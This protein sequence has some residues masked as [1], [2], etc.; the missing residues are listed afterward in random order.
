MKLASYVFSVKYRLWKEYLDFLFFPTLIFKESYKRKSKCNYSLIPRLIMKI[1][2]TFLL[3]SFFMEQHALPAFY[4]I[5]LRKDLNSVFEGSINLSLSSIILFGLFFKM[6]FDY[7]LSIICELTC[8]DEKLYDE[9][10]NARSSEEFWIRWN[11]PVHRY[12]KTYFY[13]PLI[14]LGFYKHV[15]SMLCFIASGALHEYVVSL[16]LK[17]FNGWFL[18]G[19]MA[20]VPLH[21]LTNYVKRHFSSL[22]NVFFW[23]I[24]C[25]IGQ[26]MMLLLIYKTFYL[27]NNF[28]AE[29]SL[30]YIKNSN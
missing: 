25:I 20:Q 24:F 14:D 4:R 26:P 11:I 6:F 29:Q 16:S 1:I 18:L 19:M 7:F 15:S 8:F 22:A 21:F 5:I 23:L 28:N 30:Y 10:W 2:I 3:F 9:W 12:F 13:I 27:K 17:S